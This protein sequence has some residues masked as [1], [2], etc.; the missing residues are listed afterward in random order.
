MVLPYSHVLMALPATKHDLA[1]LA[2]KFSPSFRHQQSK[3][4]G[5]DSLWLLNVFLEALKRQATK[6]SIPKK[7]PMDSSLTSFKSTSKYRP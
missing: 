6:Y 1:P 2:K 4:F 5:K 3:L 7:W